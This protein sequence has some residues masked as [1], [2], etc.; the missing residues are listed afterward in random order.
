MLIFVKNAF[1]GLSGIFKFTLGF[2]LP[3]LPGL[4]LLL[5]VTFPWADVERA[6]TRGTLI[7]LLT[8]PFPIDIY[9]LLSKFSSAY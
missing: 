4:A 6:L 3:L 1:A 8:E 5:D 9:L 7:G 2:Y